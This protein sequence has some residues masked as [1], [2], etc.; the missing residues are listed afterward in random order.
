MIAR[1]ALR[2]HLITAD[3]LYTPE[4]KFLPTG[5]LQ[6]VAGPHELEASVAAR[7]EYSAIL[8]ADCNVVLTG[9]MGDSVNEGC[10]RVY[11]DLL[12]RKQFRE[13]LRR[14]GISWQRD[15]RRAAGAL[16]YYG[17]MPFCALGRAAAGTGVQ[18]LRRGMYTNL[19]AFIPA[20]LQ[21]RIATRDRSLRVRK[22]QRLANA[23]RQR[24]IRLKRS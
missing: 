18:E 21:Q 13:V 1:F 4:Y 11:Y 7:E 14:L 9:L 3:N 12:R 8:H 19:P 23:A 10:E 20:S 22:V 5:R 16:L 24:A 6:S 15:P 17:L 2:A